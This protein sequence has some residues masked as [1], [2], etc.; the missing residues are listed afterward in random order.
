MPDG[1][2]V[3]VATGA[4]NLAEEAGWS[5]HLAHPGY[6]ARIK[7]IPEKTDFGDARL[8]ADLKRVVYLP[9]VW[10]AP[11]WIRDLRRLVRYRRLIRG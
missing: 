6:V 9:K 3:F 10:M 7:Q 8:L 1:A 11:E 4:E 2:C 5:V